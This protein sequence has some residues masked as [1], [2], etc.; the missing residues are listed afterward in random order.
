[1]N[2]EKRR[3]R[4]AELSAMGTALGVGLALTQASSAASIGVDLVI[5]G[6]FEDVTGTTAG[7][8]ATEV[9]SGWSTAAGAST[10]AYNY[11]Q[12]YDDDRN[13]VGFVPPGNDLTSATD[14]YFT[15]NVTGASISQNI[16]LSAGESLAAITAGIASYDARAFFTNYLNDLEGGE[17]TLAFFDGD[18]GVDGTGATIVGT[19]ISFVD[20]DLNAWLEVGGTG[21]ID[22][23]SRWARL[24]VG[25][26][27][28]T[29]ISSGTDVYADNVS[30]TVTAVPE[31]SAALLGGLS[32]LL[33]IGRKKR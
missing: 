18:P 25:H 9:A 17:L 12:N 20:T 11:A 28:A 8:G 14:Y 30:F 19:S 4:A 1:M 32:V 13:N 31:P 27:T 26:N 23:A 2:T 5:N 24:T 15:M 22:P 3:R 10:F 16:D 7:S 33:L 21:P 6:G 29:A